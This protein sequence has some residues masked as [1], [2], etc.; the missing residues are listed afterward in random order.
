MD[1]QSPP[2]PL[3]HENGGRV[4]WRNDTLRI[5]AVEDA[6]PGFTRVVWN[7][8]VSEMTQLSV[9]ERNTFMAAVWQVEQ[10]QRQVLEPDKVNLAQF[11]NMV[12]HL[13]WHVV[14]RWIND[15]HFPEAI[16]AAAPARSHAQAMAWTQHKARIAE[17]L[18]AYWAA[19]QQNCNASK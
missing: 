8:H 19:L 15:S 4:V 12:P 7:K 1:K 18:P 13:H 2:C 3:C 16:W 6:H 5:I 11:G 9:P 10:T 14:P 17:L